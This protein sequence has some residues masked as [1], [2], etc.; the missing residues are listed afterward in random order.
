MGTHPSSV[1]AT[2]VDDEDEARR[3]RGG[4][5]SSPGRENEGLPTTERPFH[6]DSDQKNRE[7]SWA[8]AGLG[9]ELFGKED[10]DED[11]EIQQALLGVSEGEIAAI[12]TSL[13]SDGGQSARV[14]AL[15]TSPLE[16]EIFKKHTRCFGLFF[17]TLRMERI[18]LDGKAKLQKNVVYFGYCYTVVS[19]LFVPVASVLIRVYRQANCSPDFGDIVKYCLE[20]NISLGDSF[21]KGNELYLYYALP[22]LIG[23]FLVGCLL[24]WFIHKTRRVREK[25]WATLIVWLIYLI[26][27]ASM[28]ALH[29]ALDSVHCPK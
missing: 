16:K 3:Q 26:I 8:I 21:M 5:T 27:I 11:N 12:A 15:D 24:N 19:T 17:K 2:M 9:D 10:D 23:I 18:F 25:S 14:D 22:T 4:E 1:T 6:D 20:D 13:R 28:S 7:V 29:I